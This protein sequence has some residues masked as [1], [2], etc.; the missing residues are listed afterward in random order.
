MCAMK[1]QPPSRRSQFPAIFGNLG[2]F[3]N[4]PASSQ[5]PRPAG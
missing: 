4:F 2:N 3:G 1:A 5:N